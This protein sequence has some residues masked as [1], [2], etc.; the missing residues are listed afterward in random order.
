MAGVFHTLSPMLADVGRAFLQR[1]RLLALLVVVASA[2]RM[3]RADEPAKDEGAKEAVAQQES[4]LWLRGRVVWL[5]EVLES[6]GARSVPDA[7]Q[8]TLALETDQGELIPILEDSRGHAFRADDRLR[9]MEVEL[10]ARRLPGTSVVQIIQVVEVTKNGRFEVDYW[11]DVCAIAMFELKPCDCCQ[12]E[13]EL[14]R[15]PL[16]KQRPAAPTAGDKP[17]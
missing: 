6:R 14:R 10:L 15:R 13:I 12:G 5:A 17:K 16:A 3:A 7:R 4:V 2:G 8:R 9:K 1:R 11:C